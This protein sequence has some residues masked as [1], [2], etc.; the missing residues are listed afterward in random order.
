M[1]YHGMMS[2]F[3]LM[4]FAERMKMKKLLKQYGFNSDMQYFEMV[5]DSCINGQYKQAREQFKAMSK[6]Y[7]KKFVKNI[8]GNWH[9][10]LTNSDKSKFI[11]WL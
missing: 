7:Q 3:I 4:N 6:Q 5:V 10:G 1:V 2:I 9:S 11:E 8:H